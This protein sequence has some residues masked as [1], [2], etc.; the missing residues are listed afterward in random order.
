MCNLPK[1][2]I[3]ISNEK[4]AI[5]DKILKKY[6]NYESNL[7][8][9]LQSIQSELKYIPKEIVT[10]L[11]ANTSIKEAKIYGVITFYTQFRTKPVGKYIISLCQGTAC[12]VNGSK[13]IAEAIKEKLDISEGETTKDKLFTFTNVACLGCCSLAPVMMIGDKT[14]G[15]LTP[16][17]AKEILEEIKI[18]KGVEKTC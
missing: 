13:K 7:I 9:I 18:N 8:S 6:D 4:K 16:K 2:D 15:H 10:Y 3:K 1:K 17:K 5:I 11:S 12:H 14:Y